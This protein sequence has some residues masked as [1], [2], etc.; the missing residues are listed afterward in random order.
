MFNV[1]FQRIATAAV[2]ALVFTVVTV[3]AAVVP[4]QSAHSGV[5]IGAYSQ[6]ADRANV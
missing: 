1:G 4:A 6:V 2:G 3:S 5:T